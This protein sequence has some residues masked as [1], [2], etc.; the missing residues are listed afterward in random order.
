MNNQQLTIVAKILAK[1]G[2]RDL[3]KT[4]LIKLIDTTRAEEGCINYDLHQDNDDPNLF[5]FYENWTSRDLWQKHMG[6]SH[7]AE[8]MKATEGAVAEFEINEMSLVN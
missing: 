6:N 5:L 7:L 2:K 4:E 3:V 8:Y 1:E